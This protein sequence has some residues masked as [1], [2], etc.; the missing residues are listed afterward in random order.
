MGFLD[1]DNTRSNL[2]HIEALAEKYRERFGTV[3]V[4]GIGGSSLGVQA[5]CQALLGES[6]NLKDERFT[7]STI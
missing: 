2:N 5:V 4:V 3:V 6:W 7:F 1:L